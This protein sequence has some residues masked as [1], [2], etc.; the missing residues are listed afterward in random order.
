MPPIF[1]QLLYYVEIIAVGLAI[2]G[3]L[4]F[5]HELGHFLVA[6]ACRIRVLAFS[7]GFGKALWQKKVGD[8]EYKISAIPF[9]GYVHMAGEHPEER[10]EGQAPAA[11]EFNSKPVWQRALV[12]V[13]GPGAN[14][15]FA[16]VLLWIMFM[17][18]VKHELFLDHPTIGSVADS[19]L[20]Q[21]A[22]IQPG[23]SVV[24]M[25]G[26]PVTSWDDIQKHFAQQDPVYAMTMVREGRQFQAELRFP[27]SKRNDI[28]QDHL[29]GV[30]PP[31]PPV[32]GAISS[33]SAA[34]KCGLQ[35]NDSILSVNDTRIH[36]WYQFSTLIARYDS[37]KGLL[38]LQIERNGAVSAISCAP[39]Y[40]STAKRYMLGLMGAKPPSRMIQYGPVAAI[41]PTLKKCGEFTVMIFDVLGKLVSKQVSPQQLAGPIGIVQMSGFIAFAGFSELL[42]FIALI[43]VNLAVL[44]IFPLIITDGGLLLFLLIEAV[45]GRPL[46]LKHQMILNRIAMMFFI[47]LFLYVTFNDI[48]RFSQLNKLFGR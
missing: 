24:A 31:L 38:N 42:N 44:N 28:T 21:K 32:V 13:A 48:G 20:A 46:A 30:L 19:S 33:G 27:K 10:V 22:G 34:E 11:D 6:K 5:I 4:V 17:A 1:S 41:G 37:T 23:D 39:A 36:S 18:G 14:F 25:N 26:K 16:M 8:T 43:S 2:L 7:I 35:V 9:G 40:D 3:V 29:G 15:I 12:A 47:G 45:R